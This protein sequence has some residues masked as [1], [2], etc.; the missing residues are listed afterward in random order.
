MSVFGDL[1][2]LARAGYTPA[3]VKEILSMQT[4]EAKPAEEPTETAPKEVAQPE[5][6]KAP[7]PKPEAGEDKKEDSLLELQKKLAAAEEKLA[8]LQKQNSTKDIS[9]QKPKTNPLDDMVRRFM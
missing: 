3:Q 6:E 2:A 7:D 4:E 5:T 1:V 9:E 8:D